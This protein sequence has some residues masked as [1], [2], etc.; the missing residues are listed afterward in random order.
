MNE[1][2]YARHLLADLGSAATVAETERHPAI[3]WAESGA[4]ALT[5]AAQ[6]PA[7]ICPA[8]IAACAAGALVALSALSG[9]RLPFDGAKLLGERA[10]IAGLP[11]QGAVSPGGSCRLIACADGWLALNLARDEDWALLPAWLEDEIAPDWSALETALRRHETAA[12]VEHGRLLGLALAPV[13]PPPDQAPPWHR[14][15]ATGPGRGEIPSPAPREREG[16]GAQRWEG[17]GR[18]ACDAQWRLRA[19]PSSGSLRS[20]PSPAMQEK[21]GAPLVIDLTSLWAGPLAGHLLSLLG[22]R[23]IKVESLARPD[24]ARRGPA[25]FYDLLN[26]GKASVALDFATREGR[27]QLRALIGAADIVLESTRPRA[28]EQL[29]F[30]AAALVAE[31]PGLTWVSLTGYGRTPPQAGWVAFGDDAGVAS[32]LSALL[33]RPDGKPIFCADAIAD[34]LTGLHAALAAW[35]SHLDGHS[36]LVALSLQEVAAHCCSIAPP[37]DPAEWR[38]VLAESGTAAAPP[39]ARQPADSA[40]LLGADTAEI[41]AALSC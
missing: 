36:R 38:A 3:A 13:A 4:M 28:L 11:R 19:S 32:G 30:D 26:A 12:L 37:A 39:Q 24:G 9:T 2:A 8:P 10:A 25:S 6:G 41:L 22:A 1:A 20:P 31:R 27:A 33:P 15:L 34:P 7:E 5:G 16:P 18:A 35:H 40:R 23:V 29:G 17:E 14:V 21:G